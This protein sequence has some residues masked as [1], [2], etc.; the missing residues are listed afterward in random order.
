MNRKLLILD[1]VLAACVIYGGFQLRSQWVAAKARQAG[2]PGP[3][4]KAASIPKMA[5]LPQKTAVL[6]SGYKDIAINTLFDPSRNPNIPVDPPPPP[7]PPKEPPPL[8]SFHGM[9][10]FGDPQGPIALITESG[11]AGHTEVHAGEMV[12]AFK[13]VAFNRQEMTLDWNGTVIHKRLNEGGSAQ[14]QSKAPATGGAVLPT[15]GIIPGQAPADATPAPKPQGSQLGPG[16]EVT[17]STRACQPN[18][19]TPTGAVADG[20]RK[21]V[22]MTA[23]GT[24]QCFWTAVGK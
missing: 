12:G 14:A 23:L 20:Y 7:P 8:P 18:D 21:V 1:I 11:A 15:L 24:S 3:A 10:D 4:P 6:A 16:A 19:N 9:M 2:M 17:E 13:L 5:P 22:R